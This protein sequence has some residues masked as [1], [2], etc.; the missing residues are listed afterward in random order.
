MAGCVCAAELG[1][2]AGEGAEGG[3][4]CFAVAVCCYCGCRC[5]RGA[6][7]EALEDCRGAGY[8]CLGGCSRFACV[9]RGVVEGRRGGA[10]PWAVLVSD[11]A[12][13]ARFEAGEDALGV[14]G[15]WVEAAGVLEAEVCCCCGG[16][17]VVLGRWAM[18][19][20]GVPAGGAGAGLG[21]GDR[22]V[23]VHAFVGEGDAELRQVPAHVVRFALEL[24]VYDARGAPSGH[25]G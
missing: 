11:E 20:G 5:R 19:S 6:V 12:C 17:W 23:G 16:W 10:G 8:S 13:A 4:C 2:C 25:L 15:F 14:C 3:V 21:A 9:G 1:R 22:A 24:A 7:A 18:E